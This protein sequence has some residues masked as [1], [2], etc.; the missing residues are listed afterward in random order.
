VRR[1]AEVFSHVIGTSQ[2]S[3]DVRVESALVR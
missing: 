3:R 2:K 1:I